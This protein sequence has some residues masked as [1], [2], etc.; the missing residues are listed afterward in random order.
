FTDGTKD[1]SF[2]TGYGTP[3][4]IGGIA[5]QNDGEILVGGYFTDY[6]AEKVIGIMR[7]NKTH[8]DVD[9]TFSIKLEMKGK[10]E[11]AF[12]QPDGK[13][14]VFGQFDIA[15]DQ[16]NGSIVRCNEDG[17][18]DHSF[19]VGVGIKGTW[20]Y[21]WSYIKTV[22]MHKENKI[23]IGGNFKSFMGSEENSLTRLN[24]DG[25]KDQSFYKFPFKDFVVHTIAVQE[26]G[27]ILVG[28]EEPGGYDSKFVIRLLSNGTIDPDFIIGEGIYGSAKK[29]LIQSDG[30]ILVGGAFSNYNNNMV[31]NLIRLNSDGS[32]DESYK[33]PESVNKVESMAFHTN[34]RLILLD[35]FD[36]YYG[37]DPTYDI[38]KL[39][40]EGALDESFKAELSNIDKIDDFLVQKNGQIL[41]SGSFQLEK[42][43][44]VLLNDDGSINNNFSI[45]DFD[46]DNY[47][48]MTQV[49]NKLLIS[50]DNNLFQL[51]R[52]KDQTIEF[53]VISNKF[54]NSAP[55]T[56]EVSANSGLPITFTIISGPASIEGNFIIITGIPGMVVIQAEQEGND[57]YEA[58]ESITMS[59]EVEEVTGDVDAVNGVDDIISKTLM[60]YPNPAT[61]YILVESPFINR[62]ASILLLDIK[63]L[64]VL[65]PIKT[66]HTGYMIDTSNLPQ[67]IYLLQLYIENKKVNRK[68][69]I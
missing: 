40:A 41:I 3:G 59:F 69:I 14:M 18:I 32:L 1:N 52:K 6:N 43:K 62:N 5:V 2:Y 10:L 50:S 7:L 44:L 60:I 57:M 25:T 46:H 61:G 8:G 51:H 26:N 4:G 55:F 36:I 27:R 21:D 53:K 64:K 65:I 16:Q 63:G 39:S 9:G 38:K 37:E 24:E 56:P 66:T 28:G 23:L 11:P 20:N 68:I 13:Y 31:K 22:A 45:P 48:K 33:V 19:D 35:M 34:G 15:Y 42:K 58:A 12:V 54:T 47:I 17:T 30:K 49:D 29:I 67:G